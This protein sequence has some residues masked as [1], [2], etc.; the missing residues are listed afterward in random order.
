MHGYALC[1]RLRAEG[2]ATPV[3][4]LTAKDGEHDEADALDL[5]ADD[6]LRKPFATVVLL[7]RVFALAR[8]GSAGRTANC[9]SGRWCCTKGVAR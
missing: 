9:G 6:Y 2:V 3:L 4:V 1:R 5:G 8:R 7:A